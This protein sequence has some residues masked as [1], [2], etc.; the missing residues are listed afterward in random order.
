MVCWTFGV[1]SATNLLHLGEDVHNVTANSKALDKQSVNPTMDRN[2]WHPLCFHRV[3][4]NGRTNGGPS[5]FLS[6]DNIE[7][8]QR[9]SWTMLHRG[10]QGIP[11][12]IRIFDDL[13]FLKFG[14][15]FGK[16]AE[17]QRSHLIRTIWTYHIELT[18][19]TQGQSE[20]L[21]PPDWLLESWVLLVLFFWAKPRIET[22][23]RCHGAKS[24][25]VL[26]GILIFLPGWDDIDRLLKRLT[27]ARPAALSLCRP[28]ALPG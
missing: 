28:A 1:A 14:L 25:D 22:V 2:G 13:C 9:D 8:Q 24:C 4:V 12:I 17:D 7:H 5:D 15:W 10:F 18:H 16:D 26:P 6:C 3:Q 23:P 19:L 20:A 27:K 11:R 21:P